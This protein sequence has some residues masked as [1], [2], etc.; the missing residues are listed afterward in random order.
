MDQPTEEDWLRHHIR[1]L[2]LA[3]RYAKA[4]QVETLLKEAIAEAEGRLEELGLKAKPK[5]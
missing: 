2:R 5:G 1:R 4:R 3:L